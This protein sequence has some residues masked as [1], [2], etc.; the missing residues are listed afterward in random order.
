M[1]AL[2]VFGL[3]LLT[4]PGFA[5]QEAFDNP[6]L[7]IRK[8]ELIRHHALGK[9]RSIASEVN[10]DVTYYKL[11]ITVTTSPEYIRGHVTMTARSLVDGLGTV[12]L[13]LTDGMTIDSVDCSGTLVPFTQTPSTA[14]ITMD[15]PYTMNELFTL[16]LYYQ[17]YPAGSGFGS[18]VFYQHA[19]MPWIWS[20]SEPYGARDWWP[21][22]DH[23]TDKA[24]SVDIWIT[25]DDAFMAGSNGKLVAVV[26]NGDGTK[27][28]QWSERYPI[29][30]YLVSV[31]ITNFVQFSNWFHY[32]P[33]DSMEVLNYVLPENL[34]SALLN[35]PRTVD[36]LEVYSSLFGLYPFINEKYGHCD[37]G[38]GG[39]MEHQTMT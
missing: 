4:L 19:G 28:W 31:T 23:P 7:S 34:A 8:G 3:G 12:T 18:F 26:N 1:K 11:D 32:S 33:T 10:I 38:W 37:F 39:A 15:R 27:T 30:T 36:M 21:C 14:L 24:D 5:Q 22:K 9:T 2:I 35:L 29:T 17:G 13:D 6:A 20:L 16:E 25:C